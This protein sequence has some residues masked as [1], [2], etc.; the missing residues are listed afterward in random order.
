M[1]YSKN[2]KQF[3]ND[4]GHKCYYCQKIFEI[5]QL[6]KEHLYSRKDSHSGENGNVVLACKKC[7][8]I[9][10]SMPL[11]NKIELII[12]LRIEQKNK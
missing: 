2:F 8:V 5:K 4:N 1:R 11:V 7:N 10:G 3:V 6:S 12:K 9:V